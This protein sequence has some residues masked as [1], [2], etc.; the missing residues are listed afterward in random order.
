MAGL[1]LF[2]ILP[3]LCN[4]PKA[5]CPNQWDNYTVRACQQEHAQA[6]TKYFV[7]AASENSAAEL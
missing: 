1:E 7:L 4:L 2:L 5:Y 6:A 3:G